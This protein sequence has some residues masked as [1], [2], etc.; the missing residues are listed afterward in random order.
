MRKRRVN[1]LPLI[2]NAFAIIFAST[3]L[4][5]CYNEPQFIGNNLTP[6]D[7]ILAIKVDTTFEVS[8]YTIAEDTMNT[9]GA[10]SGFIGYVNS[11]IFGLSQ[12]AFLGKF[13]PVESSEGWGGPTA[14]PDS[15][16]F[17]FTP[18]S[19]YGDTT[20]AVRLSLYE[21]MDTAFL[22]SEHNA[23][24][25]I[26][27]KY[28]TT[29]L[30]SVEYLG[31][32]T[33][34]IYLD[35]LFA[36]SLMDS[37]SLADTSVFVQKFPGFY[38][39]CEPLVTNAGEYSEIGYNVD[40]STYTIISSTYCYN[41]SF[42]LYYHYM[43]ETDGVEDTVSVS[44]AF[45][46]TTHQYF[47]YLHDYTT[48]D[49]QY[50]MKSINDTINQD[51]V[52]YLQSLGSVYGKIKLNDLKIWK[53]SF[54][55]IINRAELIIGRD[56]SPILLSDSLTDQLVLY[57]KDTDGSWAGIIP[58]QYIN[59]SLNSNG[60]YRAY[61]QSY[62]IEITSF[63]QRTLEGEIGDGCIYLAPTTGTSFLH[64]VLKTNASSRKIKLKISYTRLN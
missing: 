32:Q 16:I 64:A 6:D 33:K 2:F 3:F 19:Y 44:R 39:T 38:F 63:L 40:L 11:R 10:T 47:Q 59:Y 25:S 52:I 27:G 36:R 51:T 22:D 18:D 29:P 28:N 14:K 15:L 30:I 54:P 46:C 31:T 56:N 21:L 49:P 9:Y 17:Y 8:A 23:V 20:I 37:I 4:T 60:E 53:D 1:A 43:E 61:D 41:M 7:D 62:S 50:S 57:Y 24:N 5:S 48:S 13:L 45:T 35:T 42:V 34:K 55:V 12:G 58:D 26:D